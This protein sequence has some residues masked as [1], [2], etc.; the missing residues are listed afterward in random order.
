MP[1]KYLLS[2]SITEKAQTRSL[3]IS[4]KLWNCGIG[5]LKQFHMMKNTIYG[6]S[7][8]NKNKNQIS[9]N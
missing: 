6:G 5:N 9:F 1:I 7:E 3:F 2:C 8:K 4:R